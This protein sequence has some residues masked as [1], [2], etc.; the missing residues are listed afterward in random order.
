MKM[1]EENDAA[2]RKMEEKLL[3]M[4]EQRDRENREFQLQVMAILAGQTQT[5][6][7]NIFPF[8]PLNAHAAKAKLTWQR[9]SCNQNQSDKILSM[10]G[11]ADSKF[12]VCSTHNHWL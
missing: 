12:V 1:Q 5:P 8:N 11:E 10:T 2:S 4:E 3:E 6:G 9:V 7:H